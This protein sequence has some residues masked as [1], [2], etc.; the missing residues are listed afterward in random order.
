MSTHI[1]NRAEIEEILESTDT[2]TLAMISV[3][4]KA[5]E[6]KAKAEA[7]AKR[8]PSMLLKRI[9]LTLAAALAPK[10]VVLQAEA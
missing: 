1:Y 7:K 5:A 10:G 8:R 4:L 3:A 6:K 2:Q 9:R